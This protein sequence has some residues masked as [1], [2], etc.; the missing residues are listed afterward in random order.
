MPDESPAPVASTERPSV[1]APVR[2]KSTVQ[3]ITET[4]VDLAG[5]AILGA[6]LLTG[7]VS[8]PYLQGGAIVG[9]LL[10]AGV[11]VADIVAASKGIP[12]RGGPAAIVIGAVA[13][14]LARAHQITGG[15]S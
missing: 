15:M 9:I 2:Q 11:R 6:A 14:G 3:T 10:L 12:P 1:P 8:G 4:I 5:L 13:A 7:K